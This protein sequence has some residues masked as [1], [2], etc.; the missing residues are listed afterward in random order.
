MNP[1]DLSA[2][3]P[4]EAGRGLEEVAREL[5]RDP[6]ELLKLAS[7]ENPLGPASA[8][9][10]AIREHASRVHR[11]PTAAHSDL[12]AA[13]ADRWGVDPAQVWL[14]PGADGAIDYLSRAVLDPGD[15]VLLP[16]PGFAYYGMSARYHHGR[17]DGYTL[18]RD[19]SGDGAAEF[20]QDADAVLDAYDGHRIVHVTT[21]H[22][23]TGSRFPRGELRRL[24]DAVDDRTLVVVDE[25]Y[26]E[27]DRK[28]SAADLLDDRENVA[29]LRT[30]S[31]AYGL[32]GLRIGYG[33]VPSAWAD[34]YDRVNTPFAA[35]ELACRAAL[36]GLDDPDHVERVV[37]SAREVRGLIRDRLAA[38]THAS[39]ANFVLAEVGDA[40]A[41][42]DRARREGVIV[43]DAS[44]FGLSGCIRISCGTR[45]ET[46]D[47][48]ETLNAILAD[49]TSD[50]DADSD[51]DKGGGGG[52]E[53][54]A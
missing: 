27:Y 32:A 21:P 51:G 54:E 36:A 2:H 39:A 10:D 7:N 8:A 17:V 23:P 1:R 14:G 13:V 11:Y 42:A 49:R 34:A 38:P 29:V 31:K 3:V 47:A 18:P 43:R 5:G 24:L 28:P 50:A 4:Y 25:A 46:V 40:T 48:I 6:D 16:E 15:S 9:V 19:G 35:N 22:N 12:R 20:R 44:S 30:F 41:V 37:A 26:G 53:V 52:G 33:L 45:A